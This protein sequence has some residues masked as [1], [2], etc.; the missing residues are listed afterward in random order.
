LLDARSRRGLLAVAA[1]IVLAG[2]G[3]G[4]AQAATVTVTGDDGNPVALAQGAPG[5][6]RNMS[7]TV[8]LAFPATPARFSATVTGPDGTAVAGALT[9]FTTSSWTRSTDYRGNGNYT[10]TVTNYAKDD[11]SCKTATSTETYVYAINGSVPLTAPAGPFLIRNPNAFATNTLALPVGLNPGASTYEV[12]YAPGGVVGPDGA[13][14]GPSEQSYV[15]TSTGTTDLRFTAPG[16]YTVVARAK[17][18]DYYTPWSAPVTVTA[19]V[20]FDLDRIAFPDSRGPRYRVTG[21]VRDKAIRGKVSLAL[22]RG[23]KG[24]KY[25]PL[26]TATITSK[27]TFSKGFTQRRTGVYRLRVHYKGSALAPPVSIVSQ[28]R[29]TR[30]LF[31]G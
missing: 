11:T 17:A 21:Y 31:F 16:A 28:I 20:P 10:I 7:P 8:G 5:S 23:K 2:A 25:K 27:S 30:R 26:G 29:I 9:C 6:I 22:A 15:N 24:G 14:S 18:G 13:I 12:R 19:I 3:A 1:S 4:A